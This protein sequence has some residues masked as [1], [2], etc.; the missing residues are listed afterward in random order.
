LQG[1]SP[2]HE[3]A[4][5]EPISHPLQRIERIRIGRQPRVPHGEPQLGVAQ[6]VVVQDIVG[7]AGLAQRR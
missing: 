3:G 4:S 1:G 2:Q 7:H 5:H 6:D